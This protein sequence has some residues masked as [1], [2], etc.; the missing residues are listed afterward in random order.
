MT[1]RNEH[2]DYPTLNIG[3][4]DN[5]ETV[6]TLFVS[7]WGKTPKPED[8]PVIDE[9]IRMVGSH[10]FTVELIARQMKASRRTPAQMRELLQ[11][12][13]LHTKLKEKVKREGS[14]SQGSAYEYI[15]RLFTFSGSVARSGMSASQGAVKG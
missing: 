2:E 3:P 15:A 13:G 4:I 5:F 9:I 8:L 7:S 1:T 6:R 11:T 12:E 14:A 10:T